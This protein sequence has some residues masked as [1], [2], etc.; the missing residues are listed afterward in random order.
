MHMLCPFSTMQHSTLTF[1][2]HPVMHLRQLLPQCLAESAVIAC[3]LRPGIPAERWHQE[4]RRKARSIRR[5]KGT[6]HWNRKTT[7]ENLLRLIPTIAVWNG[8]QTENI[9]TYNL[10]I[11]LFTYNPQICYCKADTSSDVWI[12]SSSGT[13]V[14]WHSDI[15]LTFV[16]TQMQWCHGYASIFWN[17]PRHTEPRL[18]IIHK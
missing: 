12:G 4:R 15:S 11:C 3:F 1:Q 8:K 16:P 9:L 13:R 6:R 14:V 7:A 5:L 2:T 17:K 18:L 10:Y